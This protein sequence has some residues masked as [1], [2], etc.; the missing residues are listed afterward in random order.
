MSYPIDDIRN[1]F[2]IL[3]RTDRGEQLVY[4][5]NG[6]TTQKPSAVIERI[7]TF[8]DNQN[9]NIH[10]GVYPLAAEPSSIQ[11]AA[12]A[13]DPIPKRAGSLHSSH[14]IAGFLC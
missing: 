6:A 7:K 10:R 13:Q 3:Q 5:D 1:D 4:L 2:P 11:S 14:A 8:Y 9:S 12:S